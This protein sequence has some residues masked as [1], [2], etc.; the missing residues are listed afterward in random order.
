MTGFGSA[1]RS[2]GT[3]VSDRARAR[4]GAWSTPCG[5]RCG[6]GFSSRLRSASA[7]LVANTTV[8][9][10]QQRI[11]RHD[12]SVAVEVARTSTTRRRS[13]RR[14][15]TRRSCRR[16]PRRS[17]GTSTA[18]SRAC[19]SPR[20]QCADRG[21]QQE[22]VYPA[23][24]GRGRGKRQHERRE[25]PQVVLDVDAARGRTRRAFAAI[26]PRSRPT[27]QVGRARRDR[28]EPQ[29]AARLREL[30][31]DV[32]VRGLGPRASPWRKR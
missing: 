15:A 12:Q 19:P 6:R 23:G 32:V 27:G 26:L 17:A 1:A 24:D 13:S 22:S 10:L 8:D 28:V 29:H 25:H 2:A 21:A 4:R 9:T 20:A 18:G 14:P 16:S 5:A 7:S 3:R 30:A 31:Q 11:A